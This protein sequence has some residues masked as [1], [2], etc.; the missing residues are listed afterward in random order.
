MTSFYDQEHLFV[1]FRPGSSGNF[2]SNLLDNIIND[3]LTNIQVSES[4]HAHHNSIT[5]RKR[6]GTDFLSFGV[7]ILGMDRRFFS[8]DEKITY[9][10]KGIEQSNYENKMYVTWSHN[11]EN[12]PIY[13]SIFPR[14]KILVIT[15]DSLLERLVSLIMNINKNFFSDDQKLPFANKDLFKQEI[16][17]RKL[18][19]EVIDNHNAISQEHLRQI[20]AALAYQ[21]HISAQRLDKYLSADLE[22]PVPY[23]DDGTDP[24]LT[25]LEKRIQYSAGRINISNAD[26]SLR[27]LDIIKGSSETIKTAF[28]KLLGRHLT[29]AE[30]SYIADSINMYVARQNQE[31]ISDPVQYLNVIKE[32]SAILIK[33]YI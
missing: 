5:E 7:G 22:A 18:I 3:N 6:A 20:G 30:L 26:S 31:I 25:Y 12:I 11:F 27:L 28:E 21:F 2:V 29:E 23:L 4:G 24:T 32:R 9:Y 1:V 16:F 14:C 15:D 17:R 13:K 8:I 33:N 10:K 19:K